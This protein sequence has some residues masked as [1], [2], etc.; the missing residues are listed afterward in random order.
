M[1]STVTAPTKCTPFSVSLA[2][3][4]PDNKRQVSFG[5]TKGCN[6]DNSAFWLLHFVLRDKLP[7]GFQDRVVL[8]V[9]VNAQNNP[10]AEKLAA[11]GLTRAQLDFLQGPITSAAKK[12]EAASGAVTSDPKTE[13]KVQQLV[14]V[15]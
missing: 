8:D 9:R 14:T 12:V 11:E 10:L 13:A 6:A 4:A 1:A 7:E 2:V 3:L 5:I 15:T